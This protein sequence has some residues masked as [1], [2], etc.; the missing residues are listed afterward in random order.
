ME[1]MN[2]LDAF[3]LAA[4]TPTMPLHVTAAL[5]LEP[6]GRS[7]RTRPAEGGSPGGAPP[8][9]V[10]EELVARR[11]GRA[12]E[13]QRRAVPVP[14]GLD[15]P[16]WVEDPAFQLAEHL[17]RAELPRPGGPRELG[18]L[19]GDMAARPLD[20]SRPLWELTVVDGLESGHVVVAPK[21]HHAVADGI[22]GTRIIGTFLD[23]TSEPAPDTASTSRG[24]DEAGSDDDD[25]A[26]VE[27]GGGRESLPQE[28][29]LLL[30]SVADSL[31]DPDRLAAALVGSLSVVRQLAGHYRRS[32]QTP[33]RH[34]PV[35]PLS[36]PSCSISA[37]ISAQRA[38]AFVELPMED[39]VAVRRSFG[40]TINDAVL[41]SVGGALRYLLSERGEPLDRPLVAMVP[42]S[43]RSG[44]PGVD[45]SGAPSSGPASGSAATDPGG[46]GNQLS[47]ML[48]SLGTDV[49]D[50]VVRLRAVAESARFGKEQSALV[51]DPVIQGW[52]RLAVPAWT[53]RASHL[54][55]NLHLFDRVRPPFNVVV[56]SIRGPETPLWLAG[57]Q[58]AAV[59]PSGPIAEGAGVNVTTI[60]Y[61]G[62]MF[63]G[64]T[65]CR[66]LVPDPW[67]VADQVREEVRRLTK[68]AERV[69]PWCP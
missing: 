42:R 36:A 63:V 58:V 62:T 41:T 17:H 44:P 5:V 68:A 3:F 60:S 13:L 37:T 35:G 7:R 11:I 57:R 23:T 51:P 61:A 56:S 45:G 30:G 32:R 65:T 26:D 67:I 46:A 66:R 33:G 12:P 4:E 27:S 6:E 19:I 1:R 47:A 21:L 48:V 14:F 15:H 64:V 53:T 59:Y 22:L 25:A 16:V 49:A 24:A 52:A 55:S 69:G 50:P 10:I 28:H 54:I 18:A 31:R 20:R 2:G 43:V 39:L 40:G 34:A 9:A 8:F 29:Q 38:F